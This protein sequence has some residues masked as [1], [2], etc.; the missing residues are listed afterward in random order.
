MN[1]LGLFVSFSYSSHGISL[2]ALGLSLSARINRNSLIN[3][4][5]MKL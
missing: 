3:A 5:S 4:G 2:R 1:F